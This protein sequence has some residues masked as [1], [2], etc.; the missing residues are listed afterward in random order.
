MILVTG[1]V[2]NNS[3][4]EG[5]E[6][7]INYYDLFDGRFLGEARSDPAD[8]S[9]SI[10]LAAGESYSFLAQKE[11]FFSISE[12]IDVLSIDEYMEIERDLLLGPLKEGSTIRLNNIFSIRFNFT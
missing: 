3:N 11:G 4:Q 10:V 7:I 9:Y 12:R 1:R 6:S 8:G 2:L 5:V